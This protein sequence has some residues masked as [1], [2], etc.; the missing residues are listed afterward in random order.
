MRP[1]VHLSANDK[2]FDDESI[3]TTDS[4]DQFCFE[5]GGVLAKRSPPQQ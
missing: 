4:V 5:R 2:L 3:S 1:S